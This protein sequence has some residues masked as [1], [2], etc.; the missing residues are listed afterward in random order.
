MEKSIRDTEEQLVEVEQKKRIKEKE[1][2][3]SKLKKQLQQKE[4]K[5]KRTMDEGENIKHD[6][7]DLKPLESKNPSS[8][9][10]HKKNDITVKD[11]RKGIKLKK[12]THRKRW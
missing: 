3:A 2:R 6:S 12:K 11:L 9:D 8:K 10:L 4:T 7:K 1:D 5:L